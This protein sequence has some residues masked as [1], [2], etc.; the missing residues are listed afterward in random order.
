MLTEGMQGASAEE[1]RHVNTAER[2]DRQAELA[3]LQAEAEAPLDE[4]ALKLLEEEDDEDD[5]DD[6]DDDDDEEEEEEE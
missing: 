2:V 5:D 3:A 1:H 6:D 4:A